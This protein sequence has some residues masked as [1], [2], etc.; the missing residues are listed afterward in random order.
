MV[1]LNEN[2][3]R[4]LSGHDYSPADDAYYQS[5]SQVLQE[6]CTEYKSENERDH[7]F[8]VDLYAGTFDTAVALDS[9]S[10]FS[11]I[12][13]LATRPKNVSDRQWTAQNVVLLC[14]EPYA[15]F[16]ESYD[17]CSELLR[18]AMNIR[19]PTSPNGNESVWSSKGHHVPCD[20]LKDCLLKT[21]YD[22]IRIYQHGM[23]KEINSSKVS[24]AN[25]DRELKLMLLGDDVLVDFGY[26]MRTDCIML[27]SMP[28]NHANPRTADF[29]TAEQFRKYQYNMLA[30]LGWSWNPLRSFGSLTGGLNIPDGVF[31]C[32]NM[33]DD[34]EVQALVR[35]YPVLVHYIKGFWGSDNYATMPSKHQALRNMLYS[36][37]DRLI[38][39]LK[40]TPREQLT[41]TR[42]EVRMAGF[43][44]IHC[45]IVF[46]RARLASPAHVLGALSTGFQGLDEM[47]VQQLRSLI[48]PI[49]LS[50]YF[51]QLEEML[52][53]GLSNWGR[54][55][56]VRVQGRLA[57]KV[58]Q[59]K[60]AIGFN[61]PMWHCL[62]KPVPYG[63]WMDLHRPNQGTVEVQVADV[64]VE[65]QDEGVLDFEQ[66]IQVSSQ[67]DLTMMPYQ[68][69][70]L[71][72]EPMSIDNPSSDAEDIVTEADRA[73]LLRDI[74][75][76]ARI[77]RQPK[78]RTKFTF[79][80]TENPNRIQRS[81][82][83]KDEVAEHILNTYGFDWVE[84]I[85]TK[86]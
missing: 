5:L 57:T 54:R 27:F 75:R 42:F 3:L 37:R 61:N 49:P 1:F 55:Q 46:E 36:I 43:T 79:S 80:K 69:G 82:R 53:Y 85:V 25:A 65:V 76:N 33:E 20:F 9:E 26:H 50:M 86:D 56:D 4:I 44:F 47:N 15:M 84:H 28:E 6:R 10:G 39:S 83:T 7:I 64:V 21:G 59:L 19:F 2:E 60:N 38:P 32:W 52:Q 29:F 8:D 73:V 34:G 35:V 51:E 68:S 41:S 30:M 22:R 67:R 63:D 18:E 58:Q 12:W 13:S 31:R 78:H 16:I 48:K 77:K 14:D 74:L 71:H 40:D 24:S 45:L 11:P 62:K 72:S 81:F 70:F 17:R 66:L 23:K